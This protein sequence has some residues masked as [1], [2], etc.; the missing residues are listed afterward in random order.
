[1]PPSSDVSDFHIC[2]KLSCQLLNTSSIMTPLGNHGL[3]LK[4]MWAKEVDRQNKSNIIS[5]FKSRRGKR[6]LGNILERLE[7]WEKCLKSTES[8][9]EIVEWREDW[10]VFLFSAISLSAGTSNGQQWDLCSGAEVSRASQLVIL[11]AVV[12]KNSFTDFAVQALADHLLAW[13]NIYLDLLEI[14]WFWQIGIPHY[15]N[16]YCWPNG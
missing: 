13:G 9:R 11:V 8:L 10:A 4:R 15:I 14:L 3:N 6:G 1:M 7:N 16:T 2:W 12:V 5:S